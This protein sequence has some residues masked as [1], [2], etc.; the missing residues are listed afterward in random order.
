[1]GIKNIAIIGGGI[2]GL[3]VLHF[4]KKR[5][6]DKI[7]VTLYER[8]ARPGGNVQTFVHNEMYFEAGPNG[9]MA[10]GETLQLVKD[11]GL[12]AQL[13]HASTKS[14]R[15][16][17]Q[18]EG[19]LYELPAGVGAFVKS[20]LLS[21]DD[22]WDFV[23]GLMRKRISRDQSIYEYASNRFGRGAA[24][25]LFDPFVSGIF[26]GNIKRLHMASVF[27]DGKKKYK[28][29]LFSLKNG[30]AQLMSTLA[31]QYAPHIK[32]DAPIN[33]LA[34]V[35]ADHIICTVP[36]YAA[37]GLFNESH[38]SLAQ[39][40]AKVP[41]S[42]VAV[43]GLGFDEWVFRQK[44]DGYGYLIPSNQRKEVLGVLIESNIFEGRAPKNMVAL[45]VFMGGM[46]NPEVVNDDPS[47]LVAAAVRELDHIYGLKQRPRTQWVK[48][49]P[50][51]IPQ[52]EMEYPWILNQIRE[53]SAKIPNLT[54]AGSYLG[55][56][57]FNDCVNNA[58]AI[59]Y[60]VAV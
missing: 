32:T 4:L 38:F 46:N 37:Q 35:Q 1:M 51:A 45:R 24:E 17:I 7:Q 23:R 21:F 47:A 31:D 14:K 18:S 15:R 50:L 2:T 19:R 6:G 10:N 8:N 30:M 56:V 55:G 58:K 11:M 12:S 34:E 13:I 53:Q 60:S 27:P 20:K 57:S 44:P 28:G 54:L 5:L 40:L 16:Y 26:A 39:T 36:A 59:A 43:I 22:K 42:P 48:I 9:F 33:S 41:Y 49:W 29:A 3:G 52:Y 25:K